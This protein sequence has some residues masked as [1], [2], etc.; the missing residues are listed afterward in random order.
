MKK[1][2]ILLK[3]Y[4]KKL[5]GNYSGSGSILAKPDKPI[6][7]NLI[8]FFATFLT[9]AYAGANSGEKLYSFLIS[10]LP[11]A[12]SIM[13]ILFSHE[14]GHYFAA[15]YFGVRAT[16]PYF[17]PFPS[18]AGTMGAVIKIKSPIPDKRALFYIGIMGPAA[19]FIVSLVA[20]I[21]GLYTSEILPLPPSGGEFSVLIFGDSILFKTLTYII[22]GPISEGMDIFLSPYAWA[23]WLGFL[24]TSLNL[25]PLGQLDGGHI[26]Y[27]LIGSKQKHFGWAAFCGLILL[28]FYWEGWILW[29]VMT[30][31]LVMIGHPK[32]P[33]GQKLSFK[34]KAA[35][36]F[37]MLIFILTFIPI[38]VE[39]L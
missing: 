39:Y 15:R 17:I 34:E 14:M 29:I 37:I 2:D 11:Y 6:A 4:L 35:G 24:V 5:N 38:P 25:M 9:T 36:W 27:S 12:I 13:A 19:G 20:V 26:L 21:Y 18:L 23:G 1:Y 7:L 31:L 3:S 28:S 8:L 22:H 32:I 30:L 16:L 10:G 33:D